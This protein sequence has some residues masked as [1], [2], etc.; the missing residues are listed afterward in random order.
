MIP[1]PATLPQEPKNIIESII[2]ACSKDYGK[3]YGCQK[4][5]LK[6][7]DICVNCYRVSSYNASKG[8]LLN[9]REEWIATSEFIDDI[10]GQIENIEA[11]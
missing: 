9:A 6:W 7:S 11:I 4:N 2:C 3:A 10:E 5:G 8:I 1:I